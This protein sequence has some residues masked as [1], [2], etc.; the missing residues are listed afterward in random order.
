MKEGKFLEMLT[1]CLQKILA[2][3][4]V[5]V[6][7]ASNPI[8]LYRDGDGNPVPNQKMK[9]SVP[10]YPLNVPVRKITFRGR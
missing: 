1:E 7:D 3:E 4:A 8:M 2:S 10:Q 5:K 6:G 9:F